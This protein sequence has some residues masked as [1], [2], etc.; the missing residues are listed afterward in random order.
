MSLF[1]TDFYVPTVEDDMAFIALGDARQKGRNANYTTLDAFLDRC[2]REIAGQTD[3]L[4]YYLRPTEMA[5]S[6]D[7]DAP[8]AEEVMAQQ[9]A[10]IDMAVE[11]AKAPA[12]PKRARRAA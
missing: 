11:R 10:L 9:T 4:P 1:G 8:I 2:W 6:I 3:L 7:E 12:K 5:A